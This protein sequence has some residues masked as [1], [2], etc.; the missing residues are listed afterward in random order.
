ME[1]VEDIKLQSPFGRIVLDEMREEQD[2]TMLAI[3]TKDTSASI[4]E[5]QTIPTK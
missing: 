1:L 2:Q 5:S 3:T 4:A